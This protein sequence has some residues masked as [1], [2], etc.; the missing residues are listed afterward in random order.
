MGM[1]SAGEVIFSSLLYRLVPKPEKFQHLASFSRAMRLLGQGSS[2]LLAQLLLYLGVE[3]RVLFYIGFV[4][5]TC[6]WLLSIFLH[7]DWRRDVAWAKEA[8]EVAAEESVVVVGRF[9]LGLRESLTLYRMMEVQQFSLFLL[10]SNAIHPLVLTYTQSLFADLQPSI[11]PYNAYLLSLATMLSCGCAVLP[12]LF[13]QKE[14]LARAQKVLLFTPGFCAVL[15]ALM[16][17]YGSFLGETVWPS[18]VAL[19]LYQCVFEA[20]L[21]IASAA[22]ATHLCITNLRQYGVLFCLAYSAAVGL[23]ALIQYALQQSSLPLRLYFIVLGA[24]YLALPLLLL[25]V[26]CLHQ[27]SRGGRASSTITKK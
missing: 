5:L 1:Y 19:V 24:S 4:A 8:S 13:L 20:S 2:A 10:V 16:S 26:W 25:G 9:S 21:V 27:C 3:V 23:Q 17:N 6:A 7:F 15:L 22:L 11:V 14:R 18:Y 12:V